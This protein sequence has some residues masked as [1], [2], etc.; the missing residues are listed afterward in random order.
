MLG[1]NV[2]DATAGFRAYRSGLLERMDFANLKA[3]GYGFQIEGA[4]KARRTGARIVEVPIRFE[5][6]EAG[7]SKMSKGI[8][9]EALKLV[10]KWGIAERAAHAKARIAHP[11]HR[12]DWVHASL[13]GSKRSH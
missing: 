13:A 3:G 4:W 2:H 1:I 9:V 8:V 11:F 6:R 12:P 7:E 10:T 5:D